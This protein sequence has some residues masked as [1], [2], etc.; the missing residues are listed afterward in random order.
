MLVSSW[1]IYKNGTRPKGCQPEMFFQRLFVHDFSKTPVAMWLP[2]NV[3]IRR[4]KSF[5][6]VS[7]AVSIAVSGHKCDLLLGCMVSI[8]SKS[9]LIQSSRPYLMPPESD[10]PYPKFTPA[11]HI[12][13]VSSSELTSPLGPQCSI[14]LIVLP[15][16]SNQSLSQ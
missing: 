10:R 2:T 5:F 3:S 16:K 15:L 13:H 1:G 9:T 14:S 7:K 11:C 4:P 6:V 12:P 8:M